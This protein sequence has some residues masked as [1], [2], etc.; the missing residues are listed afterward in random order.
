VDRSTL[1]LFFAL[2][3]DLQI[4]AL[5]DRVA[6]EVALETGGR[7]VATENLHLTL[8]FL[9]E[10]PAKLVARLSQ[11]AAG[12]ECAAFTLHLDDVG[13]WRKT[14]LAWLGT[15]A[16]STELTGLQRQLVRALAGA[17]VEQEARPVAPHITL[18]RRI[19]TIVRRRLASPIAWNVDSFSLVQSELGREGA[20]YHVLKTW[21]LRVDTR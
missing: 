5:L 1:R 3:P 7:A 18:A 17:G 15:D 12:I 19:G 4:R 11:S 6:R 8:A 9:G 21:P 16:P 2:W 10:R 20:S 14:G 13:Y